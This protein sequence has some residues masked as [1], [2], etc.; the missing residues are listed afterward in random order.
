M[1]SLW[2]T[3]MPFPMENRLQLRNKLVISTGA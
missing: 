2:L 3:Q 1:T